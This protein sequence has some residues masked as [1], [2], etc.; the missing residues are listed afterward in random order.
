[1]NRLPVILLL[2]VSNVL[3][4]Q[5]IQFPYSYK[6]EFQ[7]IHEDDKVIKILDSN[8]KFIE[9]FNPDFHE[10]FTPSDTAYRD[11]F[12]S[13]ENVYMIDSLVITNHDSYSMDSLR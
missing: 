12:V 13:G 1:M 2:L 11:Y 8:L 5:K 6:N 7:E 9:Y 4:A 10:F 3:I